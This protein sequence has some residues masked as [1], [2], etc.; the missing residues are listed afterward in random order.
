LLQVQFQNIKSNDLTQF[1][2]ISTLVVVAPDEYESGKLIYPYE[3]ALAS[4]P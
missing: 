2:D 1:K 4:N 3:K